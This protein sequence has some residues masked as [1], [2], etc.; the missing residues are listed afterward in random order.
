[1]EVFQ[2][3]L[4]GNTQAVA[5]QDPPLY[6][7]GHEWGGHNGFLAEVL[8]GYDLLVTVVQP[9]VSSNTR[10]ALKQLCLNQDGCGL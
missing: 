1:M 2:L 6:R 9:G 5:R 4:H 3:L 7:E 10:T 8:L